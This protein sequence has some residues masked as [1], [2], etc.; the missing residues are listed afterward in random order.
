MPTYKLTYFDVRGLVE[1]SR[2]MLAVAKQPYEEVRF[3]LDFG[4]PGDFSTIQRPE[5]DAAKAAGELD[6]AL[7]KVPILEVDGV[8]IGQSK[9]IERFLARE[10]GFMGG[11]AVEAAQVD[12]LAETVR[13]IKDAYQ[14][15]RGLKDED[16]KKA[17]MEKWFAEDLPNWAKL[18][19][20]SLP[21]GPGPFLVG[22]KMSLADLTWY[23]L[24]LSPKGFFDNAEAAKASFQDCPRVKAALEA[25]DANA[26]LKEY[27][28]KRKDTMF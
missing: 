22:S 5:F 11:S 7:G 19:E 8:K 18:A 3:P 23:M 28:A 25:T 17:A 16:E 2:F 15:V 9:A 1:T 26:E 4:V 12:Q 20:K 13:D 10:L 21:A 27:I 24:L 6:A 14:K